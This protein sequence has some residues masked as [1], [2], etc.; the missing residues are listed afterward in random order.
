MTDVIT[1]GCPQ[2]PAPCSEPMYGQGLLYH[3]RSC[4]DSTGRPLSRQIAD[5]TNA[6]GGDTIMTSELSVRSVSCALRPRGKSQGRQA[7]SRI[8]IPDE[9]FEHQSLRVEDLPIQSTGQVSAPGYAYSSYPR[10]VR[11]LR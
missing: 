7:D 2:R 5:A 8:G 6:T 11:G 10:S 1:Q 9:R 3:E 4:R